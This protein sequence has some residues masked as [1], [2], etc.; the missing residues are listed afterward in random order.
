[1][2]ITQ[3]L[4]HSDIGPHIGKN[5]SPEDI[6]DCRLVC[7]NWARKSK[8]WQFMPDSIEKEFDIM[9]KKTGK[10]DRQLILLNLISENDLNAINWI[11]CVTNKKSISSTLYLTKTLTIDI[12]MIAIHN[13]NREM[14]KSLC[15]IHQKYKDMNWKI[16]YK[17]IT[18]PNELQQCLYPS[19]DRDFSFIPYALAILYDKISKLEQL[20]AQK[21]PTKE[22]QLILINLCPAI[23]SFQCL[24]F[25]L[26]HQQAQQMIKEKKEFNL[27]CFLITA[28]TYNHQEIIEILINN[29][30][31][32]INA[33]A[34]KDNTTILDQYNFNDKLQNRE[35]AKVIL[36][37]LGAKTT[38]ELQ[39]EKALEQKR[40][41]TENCTIQ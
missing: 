7:K 31:Y 10:I 22:G 14:M 13:Q 37:R 19:H 28:L 30:L 24:N 33:T 23:N 38:Q 6:D 5:L 29:K 25:L 39:Q 17:T 1:M 4:V 40:R 9:K 32:N 16:C 3:L 8:K 34:F 2:S 11:L 20:Y 26:T 21:V 18:A 41:D 27:F 12:T 15:E 35:N 36:K